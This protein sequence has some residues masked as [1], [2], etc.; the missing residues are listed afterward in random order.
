MKDCSTKP[1]DLHVFVGVLFQIAREQII[2]S[3]PE[4]GKEGK[5]YSSFKEGNEMLIPELHGQ[6]KI[7]IYGR[8]LQTSM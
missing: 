1:L 3:A 2:L 6:D 5:V 8:S 7:G 4:R